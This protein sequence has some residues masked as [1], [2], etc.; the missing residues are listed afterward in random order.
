MTTLPRSAATPKTVTAPKAPMVPASVLPVAPTYDVAMELGCRCDIC[1]LRGQLQPN[2]KFVR[3]TI[4]PITGKVKLAIVIDNPS[5]KDVQNGAPL[6]GN[7]ALYLEETLA[8][9]HKTSSTSPSVSVSP[10]A[11]AS[12][13]SPS[14]ASASST[15]SLG[16]TSKEVVPSLQAKVP[17]TMGEVAILSS[18]MC[19]SELE[20][21]NLLAARCCAP[22]LFSE[23]ATLPATAPILV[24]GKAALQVI[25]GATG[26]MVTRGFVWQTVPPTEKQLKDATRATTK[27]PKPHWSE[28]TQRYDDGDGVGNGDGVGAGDGDSDG[29]SGERKKR[30]A[31]QARTDVHLK[32]AL[33]EG[34]AKVAGRLAIPTISPN[35]AATAEIYR[36]LLKIDIT[37]ALQVL[38]IAPPLLESNTL[39]VYGGPEVLS[40]LSANI[41][42]VSLDIETDGI[43]PLECGIICVGVSG[44]NPVTGAVETAV[45]YPWK[46][47]PGHIDA[48]N[49]FLQSKEHVVAHNGFGFDQIVLRQHGIDISKVRWEDTMVAHHTFASHF[50]QKLDQLVSEYC[51]AAP[52]KISHG[53]R[54]TGITDKE[55]KK[56]RET[57]K[58]V[59]DLDPKEICQYNAEDCKLTELS[60]QRMQGD[61]AGE[62]AIYE[63]DKK[64]SY[65]CQH[66]HFAGMTVDRDRQLELSRL[67]WDEAAATS[68]QLG[69]LIGV[70]RFNAKSTEMV[71]DALYGPRGLGAPILMYT[72]TGEP[73]TAE[74]T[75]EKLQSHPDERIGI[76]CRT[77]LRHRNLVK[78]RNT[79]VGGGHQ[80]EE[81]EIDKLY[82]TKTGANHFSWRIGTV[83]GRLA[84]RLQSIPRYNPSS[85]A[86][87]CREI[88]APPKDHVYVYFDV[89][90]AEMRLAAF[91]SGDPNFIEACKGDVHGNNAKNVFPEK[92]A[93]GILDG[94]AIKDPKRGK[95]YRDICKNLGFA[96]SYLA[97]SEKVFMTLVSKGFPVSLRQVELILSKLRRA[98]RVY[99]A[100]AAANLEKVKECGYMRTALV[101]RLRWLGWHP[102]PTE[103]ANY[104]IQ[105]TLADIVNTRMI[106]VLPLLPSSGRMVAQIHD[107]CIFTCHKDQAKHLNSVI[108]E[109][110][111]EPVT[112][113]NGNG[114]SLVLPIDQKQ[115]ERMSDL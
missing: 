51:L 65:V 31:H 47:T 73:S 44:T 111:A 67:L 82:N 8:C 53:R 37:K 96:I 11:P 38:S 68:R 103:V 55:E 36:P 29:I 64:L 6:S 14:L 45:I 93:E 13:S 46:S 88:Y 56:Q 89:S 78:S 54:S 9:T 112:F 34:K 57:K 5:R 28:A 35:L 101:G 59:K 20:K 41:T 50:P 10:S 86:T 21:D 114:L 17:V 30:K 58:E 62:V 92:A 7:M 22:R 32:L 108:K 66:M 19:R 76:F 84:C 83:T 80:A 49:A 77:L 60:W 42:T 25:L 39:Y 105:G 43:K 113:S 24:A 99:Y 91:L 74:L 72:D 94:D 69:A 115:K 48:L 26:V 33:L 110:W 70:E 61:L 90:Q 15:P 18:T 100:W 16:T 2:D 71:K 79:Y 107:A 52:W 3:S 1:P 75:L 87:R 85:P 63:H 95:P 27:A 106:E 104:P 102:K 109:Q 81:L 12:F 4:P 97:E 40:A 23:L 98:Y